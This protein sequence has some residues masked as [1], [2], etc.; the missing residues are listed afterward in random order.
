MKR[1]AYTREELSKMTPEEI[2][3]VAGPKMCESVMKLTRKKFAGELKRGSDESEGQFRQRRREAVK[4]D[5]VEFPKAA[6]AILEDAIFSSPPNQDQ[7]KVDKFFA[8]SM[9][10]DEER[11]GLNERMAYREEQ[12]RQADRESGRTSG[13]TPPMISGWEGPAAKATQAPKPAANPTRPNPPRAKGK[14]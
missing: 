13:V 10:N 6:R 7:M 11:A 8:G 14:K 3:T 12:H 5:T 2:T 9:M 4:V 1:P